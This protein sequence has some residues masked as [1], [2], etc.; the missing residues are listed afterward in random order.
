MTPLV[1]TLMLLL[2]WTSYLNSLYLMSDDLK[3]NVDKP[4]SQIAKYP[5]IFG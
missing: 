1:T 4:N 3:V 5:N 2:H